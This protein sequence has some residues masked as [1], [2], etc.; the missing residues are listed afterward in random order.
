MPLRRLRRSAGRIQERRSGQHLDAAGRPLCGGAVPGPAATIAAAWSSLIREW[1][2]SSGLQC[3]DRPLLERF[4]PQ[5]A[6]NPQT[7][8]FSCELCIP[9]RAL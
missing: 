4:S 2:P 1:L 7:G 3:D 8:E 9:V 5:T 6:L